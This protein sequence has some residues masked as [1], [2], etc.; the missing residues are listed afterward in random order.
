MLS[1]SRLKG[2]IR[3][4]IAVALFPIFSV[5]SVA[6][7]MLMA[8]PDYTI[9]DKIA[10]LLFALVVSFLTLVALFNVWFGMES[11]LGWRSL[12]K[13]QGDAIIFFN[14]NPFSLRLEEILLPMDQIKSLTLGNIGVLEQ[15]FGQ[16]GTAAMRVADTGLRLVNNTRKRKP[17]RPFVLY[18]LLMFWWVTVCLKIM[19]GI[20]ARN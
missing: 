4:L 11:M 19:F 7:W 10:A 18:F 13:I 12:L 3:F 15:T 14:R 5:I 8:R 1:F 20:I 16:Q 2:F 17:S 9:G 6:G